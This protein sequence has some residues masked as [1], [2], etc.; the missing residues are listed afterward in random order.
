[1]IDTNVITLSID[2]HSKSLS[3]LFAT[4]DYQNAVFITAFNP[5]SQQKKPQENLISNSHLLLALKQQSNLILESTSSDPS[6]KLAIEKSFL[7]L[8]VDLKTSK[9][10]G[11]YFKQNAIAWIGANAIPQLILLR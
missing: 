11:K 7:A 2:Q 5:F 8:G 6:G 10:L 3:Q 9:I 1:M 4:S